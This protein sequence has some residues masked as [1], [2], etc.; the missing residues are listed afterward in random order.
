MSYAGEYRTPVPRCRPSEHQWAPNNTCYICDVSKRYL[1][2]EARQVL[3]IY[4]PEKLT[5][6][7][8]LNS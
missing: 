4:N 1:I 8:W 2:T 5:N 3:S 6:K 7:E